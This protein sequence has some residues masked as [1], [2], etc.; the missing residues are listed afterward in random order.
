MAAI[1]AD[2]VEREKEVR[3]YL[4]K[5]C[6]IFGIN[7]NVVRG[8]ITQESLFDS[9]ARSPTGAF[10]YG[11]FTRI[12]AKQVNN[13]ANMPG[14]PDAG[15][16]NAFEKT[17]ASDPNIGIKA[18]CA[19][20]W[21]LMNV[22][23]KSVADNKTLQLEACLTF[24]N[25]GGIPAYLVI[26]HGGHAA[27]LEAIKALPASKR[28]QADHYSPRVSAWIIKWSELMKTSAPTPTPIEEVSETVSL[29]HKIFMDLILAVA[30]ND[31]SIE[32]EIEEGGGFTELSLVFPG[33]LEDELS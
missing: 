8:L 4:E 20:L 9:D 21:W 32:V 11:Q 7:P 14:C 18:I 2:V 27:A 10:G 6:R 25:A 31:D 17:Q 15:G 3:P 19:T 13:I 1:R 33:S 26:K 23:Y 28:S 12:A 16:L 24:Y 5:W 22:K 29:G 30:K